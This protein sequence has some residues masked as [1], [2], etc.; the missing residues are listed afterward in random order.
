MNKKQR[1]A[2]KKAHDAYELKRKK[3]EQFNKKLFPDGVLK[4]G[5]DRELHVLDVDMNK[6]S[7]E[8]DRSMSIDFAQRLQDIEDS[9]KKNQKESADKRKDRTNKKIERLLKKYNIVINANTT[10]PQIVNRLI[11]HGAKN[12]LDVKTFRE[13]LKRK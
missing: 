8:L 10:A 6:L 9:K 1:E 13:Y 12:I 3:E 7:S 2:L 11:D 4:P 5:E